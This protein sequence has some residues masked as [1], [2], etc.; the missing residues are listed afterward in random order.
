MLGNG[1]CG[2]HL[3]SCWIVQLTSTIDSFGCHT[4]TVRRVLRCWLRS[5]LHLMFLLGETADVSG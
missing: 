4:V 1:V 2:R 5:L 3:K